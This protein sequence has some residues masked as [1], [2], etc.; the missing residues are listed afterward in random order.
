MTIE[1]RDISAEEF[2]QAVAWLQNGIDKGWISEG[3]CYTHDGDPYLTEEEEQE[4]E[5]GGDPC[6]PVIKWLL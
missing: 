1:R 3:F 2:D 5:E 6:S 4:W